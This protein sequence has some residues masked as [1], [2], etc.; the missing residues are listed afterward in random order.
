MLPVVEEVALRPSRNH[1]GQNVR[2]LRL[3]DGGGLWL[4]REDRRPWSPAAVAGF[5]A[6]K[7]PGL[8]F[9]CSFQEYAPVF[10]WITGLS[11]GGL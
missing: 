6:P 4:N 11:V 8:E 2:T 1:H 10:L 5:Q 7:R 9:S 3:V